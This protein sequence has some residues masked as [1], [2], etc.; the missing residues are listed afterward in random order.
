[1]YVL[2]IKNKAG[3]KATASTTARIHPGGCKISDYD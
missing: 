1:M 3:G 2:P